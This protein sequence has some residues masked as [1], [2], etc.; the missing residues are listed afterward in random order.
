MAD[1]LASLNDRD[2]GVVDEI[3][4]YVTSAPPRSFFLFAGAGS[5]KTRTLVAA[6][7]KLTGIGP[8]EEQPLATPKELDLRFAREMRAKSQ[9]IRVITYTKNA[10]LV[11]RTSIDALGLRS[12]C[13][14]AT[15]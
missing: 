7:R 10:A 13:G 8:K 1:Q 14:S 5:G 3:V 9:T 4:G 15:I 2:A 11:M 12:I 6:L